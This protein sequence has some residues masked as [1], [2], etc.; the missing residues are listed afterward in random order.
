MMIGNI[1]NSHDPN[2]T[3]KPRFIAYKHIRREKVCIFRIIQRKN[4]VSLTCNKVDSRAKHNN[5]N[6]KYQITFIFATNY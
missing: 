5:N 1:K 4:T 6:C 3:L 2:N